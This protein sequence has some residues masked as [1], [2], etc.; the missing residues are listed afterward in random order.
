MCKICPKSD[1]MY[2]INKV[3]KKIYVY[4]FYWKLFNSSIQVP[5][6]LIEK[7]FNS[8]SETDQ[9]KVNKEELLKLAEE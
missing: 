6:C 3:W 2:V 1:K 5:K 7:S 9:I 8:I 4:I